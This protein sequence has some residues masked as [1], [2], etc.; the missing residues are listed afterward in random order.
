M[1][2][3]SLLCVPGAVWYT[4][5]T[6]CGLQLQHQQVAIPVGVGA[7]YILHPYELIDAVAIPVV[8]PRGGM[9]YVPYVVWVAITTP[10]GCNPCCGRVQNTFCIRSLWNDCVG[11]QSLLRVPGAV[12]MPPLQCLVWVACTP[13]TGRNPCCGGPIASTA[14]K[15]TMKWMWLWSQSLL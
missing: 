6:W 15:D 2:S 14:K 9:V 13:S 8:C 7:K 10:T 4:S 5:P 3:Q 12:C 1:R 11:L